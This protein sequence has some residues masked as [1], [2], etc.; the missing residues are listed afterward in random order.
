MYIEYYTNSIDDKEIDI[1][2][3]I[4]NILPYNISAVS[5][6]L[7]QIR[8]IKK[9][10]ETLKC[11]CFVDYPLAYCD[12]NRR[13]DLILDAIK[14]AHID[15]INIPIPFFTIINRKYDKFRDD[16][17]KNLTVCSEAGVELRYMLEY[18]K[19]DHALLCKVCDI[20]IKEGVEIIYPSTGFFIDNL[21]DNLIAC[22]YLNEKTGIKTIVNGNAW[23]KD[24]LDNLVKLDPYGFS[25]N[26]IPNFRMLK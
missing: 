1:K 21:H 5:A 26:S 2:N 9:N 25:S 6:P 20:L 14:V 10:F 4:D 12:I 16:I 18:R 13:Q 7:S 17:K 15:F 22:A 19:F 3:N 24:Q 23:N 11:G 8:F